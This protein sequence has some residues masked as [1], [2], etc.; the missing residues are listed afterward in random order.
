MIKIAATLF[1]Y[2]FIVRAIAVG[3]MVS[4]CAALL[5]VSLV[6]KRYSMIGDG[7]AHVGFGAL[8]LAL[9]LNAAPLVVSIPVVIIAAFGL[10]RLSAESKIKGD[11]AVALISSSALAI[12]IIATSLK[13]G[14]NVDVYNYMF[15]SV[16]AISPV[17]VK[18]SI[19]LSVVVLLLFVIF[20]NKIF[21]ITFDEDFAAASGVNVKA[22]NSLLAMLTA[23]TIVIGMRIM[24][25]LL[26]S[27]LVVFPAVSAMRLCRS[28]RGVVICA[29]IVSFLC[30]I[31]GI[32]ASFVLRIPTGASIVAVNIAA[33]AFLAVAGK[34]IRM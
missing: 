34:F 20:Y 1:S 10:L 3:A 31:L 19:S 33:L 6:L 18:L 5:G 32:T 30:F 12:G 11:A 8:S 25:T 21:A 13:K 23:I 7:L 29:A 16:L 4:L 28:F 9:A 14:M 15:G 27:S 22:H 17:D 2:D 24:G 26:I